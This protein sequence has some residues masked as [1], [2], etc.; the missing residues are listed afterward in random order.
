MSSVVCCLVVLLGS[1]SGS[2]RSG[3]HVSGRVRRVCSNGGGWVCLG[4]GSGAGYVEIRA[5]RYFLA[6]VHKFRSVVSDA[7]VDDLDGSGFD[8]AAR[9]VGGTA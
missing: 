7:A 2:V 1:A 9:L 8:D 4:V 5:L 6:V 3:L